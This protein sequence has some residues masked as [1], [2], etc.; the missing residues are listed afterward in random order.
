MPILQT[1]NLGQRFNKSN[2]SSAQSNII[3]ALKSIF[4]DST[5]DTNI[6]VSDT[7]FTIKVDINPNC[8]YSTDYSIINIYNSIS[9]YFK[10]KMY[11]LGFEIASDGKIQYSYSTFYIDYIK[12]SNIIAFGIRGDNNALKVNMPIIV[13][14]NANGNWKFISPSSDSQY[15]YCHSANYTS[16]RNGQLTNYASAASALS[17]TYNVPVTTFAHP[18]YT[19]PIRQLGIQ[20]SAVKNVFTM[21]HNN[22]DGVGVS[23]VQMPDIYEG[24]L[25][26]NLYLVLSGSI[27]SGSVVNVGGEDYQI[28]A[29]P[30]VIVGGNALACKL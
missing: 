22:N 6:T 8:S 24:C 28:L 18:S 11:T 12:D 17:G 10:Y 16:R 13:A 25:F 5:S 30:N 19:N 29:A 14:K 7:G 21:C 1:Y 4:N 27:T 9:K 15:G 23:L 2:I 3:S 26:N 20:D